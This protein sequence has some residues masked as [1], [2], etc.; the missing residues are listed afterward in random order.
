MGMLPEPTA[1]QTTLRCGPI[2]LGPRES[3]RWRTTYLH[4]TSRDSAAAHT[5]QP[6]Q[7]PSATCSGGAPHSWNHCSFATPSA[8][9]AVVIVE[10]NGEEVRNGGSIAVLVR[11]SVRG[12]ALTHWHSKPLR[13]RR[14][15]PDC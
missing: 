4:L 12:K 6:A 7:S 9:R 8:L 10:H 3:S 14:R 2:P 5:T 1:S 15:R 13:S 11:S